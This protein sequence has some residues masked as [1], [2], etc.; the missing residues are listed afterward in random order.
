MKFPL[1]LLSV[2]ILSFMLTAC[3]GGGSDGE[4]QQPNNGTAPDAPL[5]GSHYPE[6][7]QDV[8]SPSV[9]GFYD[10]NAQSESR[11]VR[12]DL[13]GSLQAMVQFAQGHVVDPNGNEEKK[14]PRL[15]AEREALLLITPVQE[16]DQINALQ[17]EVYQNERLLRRINLA[18]P[19]QIPA[20][21]QSNRDGRAE[22]R[23]SKRAWSARLNWDEVRPGLKL[24]IIDS[25]NRSGDLLAEQIDFAAPGELVL[26]NIRIGLLTAPPHSTGHAMLLEPENSG[27]DYFQTIP[28]AHMTV[29]KYDDIQL[30][31]VMVANGTIYDSQSAGEGGV[32]SGDMRENTAKS[33][34]SVGINL[35]NWGVT[36][37]SMLSQQQPQLTQTVVTHHAR[38]KY[39]NGEQTHGLSGGNGMLTLYNSVGNEFSHE[40]GHHYGLGHYPG[41]FKVDDTTTN[42]FWSAHHADSGWGYIGYRNKMRG[43][44]AWQSSNLGDGK[45]G[46]PNFLKLYPY[47][48]DAMSGGATNSSISRYT[49][50]TGYSTFL[51]IQP[52]FTN[53][54]VWD[55]SSPSGYKRWNPDSRQMEVVYPKVP[56]SSEVWYN[57]ADG[58]YLKPR[59]FGVPVITIIGGYDPETQ[60][61]VLYPAARS[62][63]G[64]VYD[65]PAA[66]RGAEQAA[67]WLDVQYTNRSQNVALAPHRMRGNAN[68]LHVN[69]AIADQPQQVNL[70]C[71]K[72][73]EAEKLLSTLTIP[74]YG[75]AISAAVKIGREDGYTALRKVELPE[76]QQQLEAQA[77]QAVIALKPAAQLLYDSYAE[78]RHELSA[79]AQQQLQR[80]EQQQQNIYRLNRWMNVYRADL[81]HAKPEAQTALEGF[82]TQL[83]LANEDLLAEA[84]LLKNR[85]NCLKV[86]TLATG[87]KNVYISGASACTGDDTEQWI[88]DGLGRIHSKVEIDLCLSNNSNVVTLASCS[89]TQDSQVWTMHTETGTIRQGAQCFDLEHGYLKDNRARLIRYGCTGGANQQWTQLSANNSLQLAYL[90][91]ENLRLML[92]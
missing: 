13:T 70:Y 25:K 53:R 4:S 64:N 67:C 6:P 87:Q 60:Q 54:H 16:M 15:T 28:A 51:R 75:T 18:D 11:E 76:F 35:A 7:T 36:S 37:A 79:L 74:Q 47:G 27:T 12:N 19:T 21:D 56:N 80:Y 91:P 77:N 29:A 22:V 50:Y 63:W 83:G 3:G 90:T 82:V 23:Y 32:Y 73:N 89:T 9:L 86:E 65:L 88:Y 26:N 69:L 42:Y 44:L 48:W 71:K 40:I 34:F 39:S 84:T 81:E 10:F 5:H 66:Q 62:N 17:V 58:Y 78:N 46:V 45:N 43:N 55:E 92:K 57:S 33:T 1:S 52:H 41:S 72:A 30:D 2:S 8:V 68:K 61:G 59:L 49:H 85:N 20:S 14:M 31:R 38:G 24:R